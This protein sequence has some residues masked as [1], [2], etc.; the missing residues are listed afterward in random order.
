MQRV[1]RGTQDAIT[2]GR[3]VDV[4]REILRT[5]ENATAAG[6]QYLMTKVLVLLRGEAP[7]VDR[8][9]DDYQ[10]AKI[11]SGLDA[12]AREASRVAPDA[13]AFSRQAT[14]VAD[15][16]SLSDAG[17]RLN[18]TATTPPAEA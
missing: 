8:W 3:R 15:A 4:V 11:A 18:R 7:A 17:A 5:M 10:W 16:L 1:R 9:V 14:L 13:A 6:Q 12:L 2:S